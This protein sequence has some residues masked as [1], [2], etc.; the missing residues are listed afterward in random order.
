MTNESP[1]LNVARLLRSQ[2]DVEVSGELSELRYEQG[3]E[4]RSLRFAEPAPF[5]LAANTLGGDDL[6]LAGRFRPTLVMECGRCLRPVETPVSVKI[7]TLMRYDP[8]VTEP[9]LDEAES[10]EEVFVFG[11]PN[12]DL[13]ALLAENTLIEA[14]AVVLH[15]PN[16][17]GLCQ[18]CGTDLNDTTC[19]H[20]AVVPIEAPGQTHELHLEE[21]SPFAKLRGLE[22]P[23]E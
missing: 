10:G 3:G 4:E 13:S 15:D 19:A 21:D 8:A 16:C 12:I 14:P 9:H 18:V 2:G 6:W 17:K 20:A 23:D 1:I 5:Q 11:D 22:L 7:G